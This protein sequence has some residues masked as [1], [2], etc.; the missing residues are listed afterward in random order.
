MLEGLKV[1]E[2]STWVAGPSAAMVMADWGADV[3]KVESRTGDPVR[4]LFAAREDVTGNPVFDLQNRGKRSLVLD[5]GTADGR[6]ALLRVLAGAD[7]FITNLRPGALK[8]ARLDYDAI[9]DELPRLI[10]AS[11]TGYGLEGDGVDLPAFD[12]AAFWT[13]SGVGGATIPDG[14]DP[15]FCRPGMGDS[16][17]A[18]ATASAA[19]AAVI[20][21]GRTGKGRLVETSL[22]RTGS[23][24]VG[25]D[26]SIQLKFG[27][28]NRAVPRARTQSAVSNYFKTADGHWVSVSVRSPRDWPAIAAGIGHPELVAD[29]RFATPMDR[30][31]NAQALLAILDAAFSRLSLD[32]AAERLTK[33][34]VIWAPLQS[35]AQVAEDPYAHAAG[36]FIEVENALGERFMAPA[37]PARLPGDTEPGHRKGAPPL[38]AHTREILI[39]AGYA[40]GEVDAL[41]ESG[42]AVDL[43]EDA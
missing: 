35:L 43:R 15:F 4:N 20:E 2:F 16:A 28:H 30:V 18:L 37:S 21:R 27:E 19:L 42:A 13:R 39:A 41:V 31:A 3:I 23:Y 1:V 22:I 34:D 9:K 33:A 12:L 38:G 24:A 6:A 40:P 10:Y 25:W 17:C 26:L 36:C 11:V 32:E 14:I 29:P 8:R 5:T 7:I